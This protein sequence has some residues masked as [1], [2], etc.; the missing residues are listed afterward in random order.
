MK[1]WQWVSLQY[2][3]AVLVGMEIQGH[4]WFWIP[5][6]VVTVVLGHQALR[7]CADETCKRLSRYQDTFLLTV[8]AYWRERTA[9]DE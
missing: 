8:M 1:A 7:A 5:L 4:T 3:G 6:A 2:F 9:E